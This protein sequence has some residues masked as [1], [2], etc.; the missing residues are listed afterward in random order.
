MD[1]VHRTTEQQ[2]E[3]IEDLVRA[4]RRGGVRRMSRLLV[5]KPRREW[6]GRAE[7]QIRDACHRIGAQAI[8][9]A[10]EQRKKGG[11]RFVGHLP[12]MS[13][14]GEIQTH[15]HRQRRLGLVS[16]Q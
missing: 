4:T 6:L 9:A 8:D 2:A 5:S 13:A 12:A 16:R 15:A 14:A 1:P 11:P 10:L 7:F 3:R